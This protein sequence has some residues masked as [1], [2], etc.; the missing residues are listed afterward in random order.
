MF[1]NFAA[2]VSVGRGGQRRM[3]ARPICCANKNQPS[4]RHPKSSVRRWA[5]AGG[6]EGDAPAVDCEVKRFAPRRVTRTQPPT[7]LRC[8]T[9]KRAPESAPGNAASR[10]SSKQNQEA[11]ECEPRRTIIHHPTP[12]TQEALKN[13]NRPADQT[14]HVMGHA[15]R[16]WQVG[17]QGS[18][19]VLI[20]G[21]SCS[22]LG[23]VTRCG[24]MA[25]HSPNL[26]N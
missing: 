5:A 25:A 10:Q 8:C 11:P 20:H 16:F 26:P 18:P 21:F 19:L 12:T 1:G 4:Y 7:A 17:T 23:A 6:K 9:S 3:Q 15:T 24:A 2:T 13:M 14:S 22:V